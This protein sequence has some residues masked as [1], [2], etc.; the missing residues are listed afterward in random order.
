MIYQSAPFL[1]ALN[2]R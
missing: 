2:D 1:K